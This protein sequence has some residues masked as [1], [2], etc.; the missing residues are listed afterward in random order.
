LLLACSSSTCS[1]SERGADRAT[2]A[3]LASARGRPASRASA[4]RA[5][6]ASPA[7]PGGRPSPPASV[8][9]SS[10]TATNRATKPLLPFAAPLPDA[11]LLDQLPA[12]RY[13]RLGSSQCEA[14]LERNEVPYRREQRPRKSK[15]PGMDISTPLRLTGPVHGV[16][17]TAPAAPL[18]FGKL[19]CRLAL[20]LNE[21]ARLLARHEVVSVRV[22]SMYRPGATVAG[23]DKPSQ[24]AEGLAIDILAFELAGE[25]ELL[26]ERDWHGVPGEPYCGP[27]AV[28]AQRGNQA[29]TR[30]RNLV[31]NVIRRGIFH[32]TVTPSD[33]RAHRDHLH[34]DLDA[35]AKR[36]RMEP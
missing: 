22:D 36:V 19:D 20:A 14:E 17:F 31:C 15:G 5:S 13:A 7:L 3:G 33:N 23:K 9:A 11:G 32:H 30:L 26:V 35:D 21:M 28:L 24:H 8:P 12:M 6:T 29:A 34:F 4:P 10:A 1:R 16:T 25:R 18:P 2:A 27:E